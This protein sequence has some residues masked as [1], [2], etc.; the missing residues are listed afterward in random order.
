MPL[1][2]RYD[3]YQMI[4]RVA[5]RR[6]VYFHYSLLTKSCYFMIM[7]GNLIKNCNHLK[8]MYWYSLSLS[9]HNI[10]YPTKPLMYIPYTQPLFHFFP[11]CL[12]IYSSL[13][14]T[15]YTPFIICL[16]KFFPLHICP[17]FANSSLVPSLIF[18]SFFLLPP[19]PHIYD[20]G[21]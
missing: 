16:I 4:S 17:S 6:S 9:S 12:S 2:K 13:T 10:Y 5:I 3:Y 11:T 14:T 1:P 18:T 20:L 7:V 8:F 21:L 19:P 15:Y